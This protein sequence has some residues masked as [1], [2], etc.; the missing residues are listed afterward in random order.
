M[1]R[2]LLS[3]DDIVAS[4]LRLPRRQ[5]ARRLRHLL[6]RQL[7]AAVRRHRG[8]EAR[9]ALTG[10]RGYFAMSIG[11]PRGGRNGHS[12]GRGSGGGGYPVTF[13]ADTLEEIHRPPT[14]PD[15]CM[16][17]RR[18]LIDSPCHCPAHGWTALVRIEG[19]AHPDLTRMPTDVTSYCPS[20]GW[21]RFIVTDEAGPSSAALPTPSSRHSSPTPPGSERGGTMTSGTTILDPALAPPPPSPGPNPARRNAMAAANRRPGLRSRANEDSGGMPN[22]G[23]GGLWNG[24]EPSSSGEEA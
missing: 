12:G 17:P 7:R 6:R 11:G 23:I 10:G 1:P 4:V 20:H 5:R 8:R 15:S 22:G 24:Y 9:R 3:M 19:R 13:R 21:T 16:A 18:I 2:R 14:P